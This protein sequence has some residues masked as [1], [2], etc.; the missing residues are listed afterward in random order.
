MLSYYP[1]QHEHILDVVCQDYSIVVIWF[2]EM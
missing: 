2:L 1:L